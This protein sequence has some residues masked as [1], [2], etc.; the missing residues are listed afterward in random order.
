[1]HGSIHRS[2]DYRN[3]EFVR[4]DKRKYRIKRSWTDISDTFSVS[5]FIIPTVNLRRLVMGNDLII[6][7][8]A[9]N[10]KI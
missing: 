6:R 10:I 8:P 2:G 7:L 3:K 1:M 5:A 4:S 9:G